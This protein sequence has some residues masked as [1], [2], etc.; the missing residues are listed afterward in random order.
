VEP[1]PGALVPAAIAGTVVGVI[2]G[3][4]MCKIAF[5]FGFAT[6]LANRE[7]GGE[8]WSIIGIAGIVYGSY[9]WDVA[10]RR[11]ATVADDLT[12]R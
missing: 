2:A 7:R 9:A 12:D 10:L 11:P 1:R 6:V 4:L 5:A 3:A 8:V